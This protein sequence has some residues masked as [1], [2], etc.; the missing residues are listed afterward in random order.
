MRNDLIIFHFENPTSGDS[1]LVEPSLVEAISGAMQY[2]AQAVLDKSG[3][4]R[5]AKVYLA[6]ADPFKDDQLGNIKLTK[7]VDISIRDINRKLKDNDGYSP[8]TAQLIFRDLARAMNNAVEDHII[9]R[10]PCKESKA[11][12][13]ENRRVMATSD[14]I[15]TVEEHDKLVTI[16][17]TWSLFLT[18]LSFVG[19]RI[20]EAV[21][22]QRKGCRSR[23]S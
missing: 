2:F 13:I 17:D 3:N 6:G 1:V 12:A 9:L 19:L 21:G 22:L 15:L 7:L 8:G 16:A 10:N 20:G 11:P 23:N 14:L 18:V 5:V 4:K